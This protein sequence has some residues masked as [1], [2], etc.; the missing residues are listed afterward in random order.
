MNIH[1]KK[2]ASAYMWDKNGIDIY[3]WIDILK[4]DVE[5]GTTHAWT[6]I[7]DVVTDFLKDE[8]NIDGIVDRGGKN[9]GDTHQVVI[10]FYSNQI[11]D[12]SN[13]KPTADPNIRF[14]LRNKNITEETEIPYVVNNQYITVQKNNKIALAE[15]QDRVKN[16]PRGTYENKATGYKANI[17]SNTINKALKPTHKKFNEYGTNYV[18]NLNAI[19]NLP[20][21]FENAVYVDT[22][23]NQ[24][25]KN[26]NKEIKGL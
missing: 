18:N 26:A 13:K 21:L 11:K 7:P 19:L 20:E 17:N 14:S 12:V 5:R 10:P 6:I 23:E 22:I 24:K 15:L 9:G 25:S 8:L 16:L 1:N 4:D 2:K 3:D